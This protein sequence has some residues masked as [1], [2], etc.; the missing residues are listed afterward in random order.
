MAIHTIRLLG[1]EVLR[2]RSEEVQDFDRRLERLVADMWETMYHAEGVGL[3]APQIGILKRIIVIDVREEG[4]MRRV[5][6]V[7]PMIVESSAKKEKGPEGCLSIPG[8]EDIVERSQTVLVEGFNPAGEPL[9][10]EGAGLFARALQH[11]IDH[12]DGILFLDR[13]SPLK[14]KMLMSK[15]R[16]SREE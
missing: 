10:V 1:D 7:N 16:K 12:L 4:E 8:L 15:W 5:A 11:E 6:L 14:R 9:T 2:A 13:V 3:A